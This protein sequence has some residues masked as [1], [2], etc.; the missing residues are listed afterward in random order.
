[1]TEPLLAA[2]QAVVEGEQGGRLA[3]GTLRLAGPGV[4]WVGDMGPLL[5]VLTQ[6][7]V[8]AQGRLWLAG[9]SADQ[10]VRLHRVGLV[11]RRSRLPEQLTCAQYLGHGCELG[12]A[13]PRAALRLAQDSLLALGLGAMSERK[14]G[15]L[16]EVERRALSLAAARAQAPQ[17]FVMDAPLADLEQPAAQWLLGLVERVRADAGCLIGFGSLPESGAEA[18]LAHSLR[19]LVRFS[20]GRLVDRGSPAQLLAPGPRV[21]MVLGPGAP[22]LLASLEQ[23][24]WHLRSDPAGEAAAELNASA[25]VSSLDTS[26]YQGRAPE[27]ASP[28]ERAALLLGLARQ[29]GVEV[30]E[31]TQAPADAT[32]PTDEA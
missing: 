31:L 12:G 8:V 26:T 23:S 5:G 7:G 13:T 22:R 18:D 30:L 10:A 2:E 1:M 16:A 24:G 29:A 32:R 15:S 6:R 19:E 11:P 20:S 25:V 4:G 27:G 14:I 28:S 17:L 3:L 21:R 9:A